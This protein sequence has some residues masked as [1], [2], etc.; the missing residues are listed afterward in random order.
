MLLVLVPCPGK[1]CFENCQYLS[2]CNVPV[3]KIMNHYNCLCLT[4][5]VF[6]G[7]NK[8]EQNCCGETA[9][10]VDLGTQKHIDG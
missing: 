10:M 5:F 1:V 2:A 9:W 6:G 7:K 3:W 4:C 8:Y